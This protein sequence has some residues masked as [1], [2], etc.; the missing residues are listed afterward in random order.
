[1]HWQAKK[2]STEEERNVPKQTEL[3]LFGGFLGTAAQC[4]VLTKQVTLTCFLRGIRIAIL[5]ADRMH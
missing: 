4:H 1:M 3:S 5:Q 2:Q